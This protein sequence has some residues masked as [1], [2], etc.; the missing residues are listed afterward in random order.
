MVRKVKPGLGERITGSW[1]YELVEPGD[2]RIITLSCAGRWPTNKASWIEIPER[3]GWLQSR[4]SAAIQEG[5]R[6]IGLLRS[7]TG[8][9]LCSVEDEPGQILGRVLLADL[10]SSISRRITLV[11]EVENRTPDQLRK[12]AVAASF[13][14]DLEMITFAH[15]GG[16]A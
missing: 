16:G 1:A 8:R 2:P 3:F 5:P 15:G 11:V 12:V 14:A 6:Q 9:C 7:G 4:A 10:G 13:I